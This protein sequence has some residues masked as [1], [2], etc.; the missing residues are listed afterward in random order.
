[1]KNKIFL[2]ALPV[3]MALS[4]CSGVN[5][6]PKADLMV[7]DTLAHE[8]IFG[9]V[10]EGGYL[11]LKGPNKLVFNSSF[12]KMGYQIN[13]D[14]KNNA[15]D[16]DDTIAIRF[17]A[18]IK[19][20]GVKAYWH[21]GFAQSNGWEGANISGNWKYKLE[22]NVYDDGYNVQSKKI[23]TSLTDGSNIITADSGIYSGYQ[24]FVI[25]TLR[26]IPYQTYKDAY[27]GVYLELQDLSN[28]SEPMKSD[29]Y[30][31]KVEK[32]TAY[33]SKNAFSIDSAA[34]NNKYF[35]QG[36]MHIDADHQEDVTNLLVL[37]DTPTGDN[38][39][40][41]AGVYFAAN[42]SFGAFRFKY[43]HF[44][45]FGYNQFRQCVPF[46]ERIS[47]SNYCK[48]PSAGSHS[49]YIND[50]DEVHVVVPD[51]SNGTLYLNPSEGWRA[52]KA[53][54][55]IYAFGASGDTWYAMETLNGSDTLYVA[56]D[57]DLGT[58]PNII[59]CRMY[60]GGNTGWSNFRE[61]IFR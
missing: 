37:D 30:A 39:A 28:E 3:L 15:D 49:I 40:Q 6:S 13:Y 32:D 34:Y 4:G 21:R 25:Y 14:N 29:F 52:E 31:V 42:D 51:K 44:Q 10:E 23:Y 60:S 8:E 2:L 36:T 11:G 50:S 38:V 48:V 5:A 55:A 7:E 19:N 17:I 22:D 47:G 16:S 45:C 43:D 57:V 26:G 46:T 59:F 56:Y 20:A 61:Q 12:V 24:G 33:T 18:A 41:K 9:S 1:M 53:W 27:L 35:L 58:Y 54:F